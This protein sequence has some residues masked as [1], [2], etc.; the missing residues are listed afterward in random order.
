[1]KVPSC[2]L[3]WEHSLIETFDVDGFSIAPSLW[4]LILSGPDSGCEALVL[5]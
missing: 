5:S 4:I 2:S 3:Q 1:M